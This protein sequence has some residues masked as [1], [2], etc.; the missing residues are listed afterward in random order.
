MFS[1]LS[2][3]LPGRL[4]LW[5]FCQIVCSL[6]LYRT[7][8]IRDYLP[9]RREYLLQNLSMNE[10]PRWSGTAKFLTTPKTIVTLESPFWTYSIIVPKTLPFSS[11]AF[12]EDSQLVRHTDFSLYVLTESSSL[13]IPCCT[14][15][16]DTAYGENL[17]AFRPM[18]IDT[19]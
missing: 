14:C 7:G 15:I 6:Y 9:F 5:F 8:P 4:C 17:I 16:K 10:G 11:V 19:L 18:D 2:R 1:L 3:L 12:F 13:H